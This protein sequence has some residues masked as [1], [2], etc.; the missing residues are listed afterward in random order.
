MQKINKHIEIVSSSSSCLSSMSGRS[1]KAILAVLEKHYSQVGITIV[2][3]LS[4]LEILVASKPDLV[5]LGMKFI[6]ENPKLGI[7]DP[8]KIWLSQYLDEHGIA[9][10]GSNQNAHKLELDKQLAKQCVINAGLKTSRYSIIHYD[11]PQSIKGIALAFPLFVK[12]NNRGGG[13][14]ISST[15]FVS[16][17]RELA[18]KIKSIT[19]DLHSDSLIEEYLPGREFSVAILKAKNSSELSVMPIELVTEPNSQGARILGS[20]VKSADT[21]QVLPVTDRKIRKAVCTLAINVFYALGARDYGR[22]D[23]RLDKNGVPH[24]LEANL[25]PSLIDGYGNFPKACALNINLRFEDM[26]LA[27]VQ[28]AFGRNSNNL[29]TTGELE[30]PVGVAL[31][32]PLHLG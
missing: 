20:D 23:I 14:G 18:S 2:N 12:P 8:N 32:S 24:F 9:Y 11:Q 4:D 1:R 16:N 17:A 28:T 5:F 26:L 22:I 29:E 7:N 3:N 27:I 15:S 31:V 21:E 10:T 25:I 30:S 6:P 19:T 13:L